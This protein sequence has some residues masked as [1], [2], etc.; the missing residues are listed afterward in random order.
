MLFFLLVGTKV[1]LRSKVSSWFV[2]GYC[3]H[4]GFGGQKCEFVDSW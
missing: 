3:A 2:I 4:L 1:A